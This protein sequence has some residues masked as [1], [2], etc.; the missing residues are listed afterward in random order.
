M[1][2]VALEAASRF[3]AGART[4]GSKMEPGTVGV[5]LKAHLSGRRVRVC[6]ASPAGLAAHASAQIACQKCWFLVL[7]PKKHRFGALFHNSLISSQF[8]KRRRVVTWEIGLLFPGVPSPDLW[9][10]RG[11]SEH[12][13]LKRAMCPGRGLGTFRGCSGAAV[14]CCGQRPDARPAPGDA[15]PRSCRALRGPGGRQ[16]SLARTPRSK[17]RADT[18][19][20][21]SAGVGR[22]EL[23]R[24]GLGLPSSPRCAAEGGRAGGVTPDLWPG[25]RPEERRLALVRQVQAAGDLNKN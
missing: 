14:T 4:L 20:E 25:P 16:H 5:F 3:L 24:A 17:A 9:S 15:R 18:D 2:V 1:V 7:S 21:E 11:T 19:S 10:P 23:Q 8:E 13:A 22:A 6:T 12:R